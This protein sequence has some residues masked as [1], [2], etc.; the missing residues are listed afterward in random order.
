MTTRS[1]T[2]SIAL[3]AAA[4]TAVSLASAFTPGTAGEAEAKRLVFVKRHHHVFY[5]PHYVVPRV[6]LVSTAYVGGCYYLKKN[7]L[8]TGDPHWWNRYQTC[9]GY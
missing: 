5:R 7:A 3:T 6:A 1:I 9:R 8:H 2:K 4:F